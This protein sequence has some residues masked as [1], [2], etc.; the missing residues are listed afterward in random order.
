MRIS[1]DLRFAHLS[2]GAAVY[3]ANLFENLVTQYPQTSWRVYYNRHSPLQQELLNRLYSTEEHRRIETRPVRSS[4]LTLRHHVEFLAVRDDADL[5]HYPHF[6]APL[7]LGKVPLVVTIHDLYPLTVGGYC[8]SA[9]RAYFHHVA[10]RNAR[11][12]AAVITISQQSKADILK[13]LAVEEE[14]IAVIPQGYSC[15]YRPIEDRDMLGQTAR[16]YSLP[17]SFM[18]YTGNHKPH[19][20]LHRL[21]SAYA[22][23]PAD[24]RRDYPLV[25][26]GPIDRDTD[27][28]REHATRLGIE[29]KVIFL[30]LVPGKDLPAIN[31]LAA[32]LVLPSICEGFGATPLQG[33]ACG[34]PAVC[35]NAPAI[36]EVLG[37]ACRFFD[38][39]SVDEMTSALA[40]SVADDVNNPA[41]RRRSLAQAA[42]YSWARTAQLTHELYEAL[43]S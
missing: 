23:L 35:S 9:K 40:A 13:H 14:K 20:N 28:L 34:T 43:C 5:Y 16:R 33:M 27:S 24:I 10:R 22:N 39:Y 37:D 2:G 12:A 6:D 29:K 30:G 3:T 1:F 17:D 38:P 11:R 8:S 36:P 19:K 32:L 31:N 42:K 18:L 41:V 25:L 15:A 7:G 26:T 21:F 4:C